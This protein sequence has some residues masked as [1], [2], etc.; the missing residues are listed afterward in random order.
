MTN[1]KGFLFDFDGTLASTMDD[2]L[3]AWA[4]VF[5]EY[6]VEI[7]K[8]DLFP[9]E[10]MELH[11]LAK[12][13]SES[14]SGEKPDPD[15]IVKQKDEYYLKN[16][17]F[18]LYP[19][20]DTTI[21]HLRTLDIRLGIVTAAIRERV[22]KSVPSN[23]LSK[24]DA[25]ITGDKFSRGKPFPDPYLKGALAL[26]LRPEQ[27]L[28]VENAPLGVQAAKGAGSYCVAVCS[29]LDRTYF[30]RADEVIDSFEDL[31]SLKVVKNLKLEK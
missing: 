8:E 13:F 16:H 15:I 19:G 12:K 27:C 1:Y 10:G 30:E 14:I 29:T 21:D 22:E 25:L 28:V 2:N 31:L 9:N 24:F 4:A 20:V 23:F 26:N 7:T 6:G 17:N 3:R 5:K 18:E 11:K